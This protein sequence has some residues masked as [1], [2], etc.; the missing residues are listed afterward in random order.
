MRVAYSH[1]PDMSAMQ[2]QIRRGCE[3]L[4]NR[5]QTLINRALSAIFR[6]GVLL[7]LPHLM[8][9]L[10]CLISPVVSIFLQWHA[11]QAG[12]PV[13]PAIA[14]CRDCREGDAPPRAVGR[15]RRR[16]LGIKV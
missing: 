14:E 9:A 8:L 4:Q 5:T 1:V 7:Y 6:A 10:S 13:C 2:L 3:L 12:K 15:V 11:I 16:P